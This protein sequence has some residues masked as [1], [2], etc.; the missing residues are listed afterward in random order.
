MKALFLSIVLV[1]FTHTQWLTNLAEAKK[2]AAKSHKSILLNFSGSDWCI[3]CMKLKKQVFEDTAFVNYAD[4][5]LVLVNADFPRH[6]KH[7]LSKEQEK[8]N[9]KMAEQYNPNGYFP[10]T[11]LLDANGKVLKTWEGLPKEN[12]AGFVQQIKNAGNAVH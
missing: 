6:Q 11:L 12:V 8:A 1:S 2:E 7:S 9:E 4:T 5:A 10:F 3:P